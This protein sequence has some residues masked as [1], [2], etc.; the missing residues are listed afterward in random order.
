MHSFN[1]ETNYII[2]TL[3]GLDEIFVLPQGHC[4]SIVYTVSCKLIPAEALTFRFSFF[5]VI[6][7]SGVKSSASTSLLSIR[8]LSYHKV[9]SSGALKN[10]EIWCGMQVGLRKLTFWIQENCWNSPSYENNGKG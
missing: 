3:F 8:M 5:T 1:L 2:Y 10:T 7:T 6:C 4:I 9:T